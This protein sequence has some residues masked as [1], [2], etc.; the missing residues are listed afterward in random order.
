MALVCLPAGDVFVPVTIE[1]PDIHSG[2]L[3]L[4]NVIRPTWP[5]NNINFKLFTDG[6]TNKLVACQLNNDANIENTVLVRI[7]GNKTDLLIDRNA[8]LRNIKTLNILGLAP[9]VYGI[10]ENGIAYQYYPGETLDTE[11]VLNE[12]IWPL[13][14]CY[15]AK[16][17]KVKLG[18]EVKEEPMVWDKIEQFLS[19]LPEPFT[20]VSKQNRFANS[21]GSISR[22]RI[23]SERLK[24]HL[25]KTE[26]PIVF[27]HNDLLLGNVIYNKEKGTVA[28][29]DYEYAAYNY[30]AF[31]IANHFN[32]YVG[33]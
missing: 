10:F 6:I 24:T 23:E 32:E 16:M 7:Y 31:D 20:D 21:F 22:L 26:S 14:A 18:K 17:H 29:I 19:L 25:V 4:L 12:K 30:Q 3:K 5:S 15:M 2:I 8:E 27:A 33:E 28:F 13:V 9:K 11:T 1:E